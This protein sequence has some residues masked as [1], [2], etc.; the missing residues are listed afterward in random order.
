MTDPSAPL[1]DESPTLH[2]ILAIDDEIAALDRVQ[3]K[4][5]YLWYGTA[6]LAGFL[7]WAITLV[8][9]DTSMS[10]PLLRVILAVTVP[11]VIFGV[12]IARNRRQRH[13]LELEMDELAKAPASAHGRPGLLSGSADAGGPTRTEEQD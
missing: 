8:A 9:A 3:P 5:R 4:S 6:L 7:I 2:R 12:Q 1:R 13:R 11:S 10:E